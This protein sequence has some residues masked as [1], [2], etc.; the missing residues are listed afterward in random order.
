MSSTIQVE[1][2]TYLWAQLERLIKRYGTVGL[3]MLMQRMNKTLE[4]CWDEAVKEYESSLI[5]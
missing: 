3:G 2:P 4:T 1:V 5:D